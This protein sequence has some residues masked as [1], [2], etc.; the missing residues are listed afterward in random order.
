M[1]DQVQWFD[2]LS[3]GYATLRSPG[4]ATF[5]L[6]RGKQLKDDIAFKELPEKGF[7]MGSG[8]RKVDNRFKMI[9][10]AFNKL[11]NIKSK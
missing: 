11:K 6:A 7:T 5:L 9:E 1:V 8:V 10:D 4:K 2:Q 3:G